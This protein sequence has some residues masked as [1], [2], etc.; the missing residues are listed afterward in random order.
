M[1]RDDI[2]E[3]VVEVLEDALGADPEDIVPAASLTADLDAESIDF[4]DIV[5]KLE[6]TFGFKV[7]QGELFPE[8][9]TDNEEWVQGD[10]ITEAG[11]AMLQEKLPH[12]DLAPVI[13]TKKVSKF[14]CRVRS[15]MKVLC[16]RAF[17]LLQ[18]SHKLL[19]LDQGRISECFFSA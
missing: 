17:S 11:M 8:N 3:K 5:F 4:L 7:A 6:Q 19:N 2:M 14:V 12:V 15:W 9:L 10:D 16:S 18:A 1:T 13:E